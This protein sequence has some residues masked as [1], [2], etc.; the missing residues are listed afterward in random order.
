MHTV[1]LIAK[2]MREGLSLVRSRYGDDALILRTDETS[3]GVKFTIQV[4]DKEA[5]EEQ[6][7]K[8][9]NSVTEELKELKAALA[10]Q[11]EE[12]KLSKK[13]YANV[14]AN[15]L[16]TKLGEQGF[17][18]KFIDKAIE[19]DGSAISLAKMIPIQAQQIPSEGRFWFWGPTGVGKTL[20][21]GK[22]AAQH[23]MQNGG[24]NLALVSLDKTRIGSHDALVR[25]GRIFNAPVIAPNP[26][27]TLKGALQDCDKQCV[28][29]DTPGLNPNSYDK[30][31]AR[32]SEIDM[33]I[34]AVVPTSYSKAHLENL[35]AKFPPKRTDG[36][37]ISKWDESELLGPVASFAFERNIPLIAY[38][39]GSQIPHDF[40]MLTKLWLVKQFDTIL[41]TQAAKNTA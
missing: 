6:P 34:W 38:T 28:F 20:T 15:A 16:A 37:I 18:D 7:V 22:I 26:N 29:I 27:E 19:T 21:L 30:L 14:E 41:G 33:K 9:S 23:I 1:S 32:Q 12:L 36:I 40:G 11:I 35:F 5:Q 4:A 3:E 24:G 13:K 17:S 8:Q 25:L 31:F 10:T 2:S 39:N